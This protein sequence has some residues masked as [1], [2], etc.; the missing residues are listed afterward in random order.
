MGR[1][2][3]QLCGLSVL[4]YTDPQSYYVLAGRAAPRTRWHCTGVNGGHLNLIKEVPATLE[5]GH[6]YT[7][8]VDARGG[9]FIAYLD[10]KQMFAVD[11]G[12]LAKGP[13]GF[14]RRT[15][16]GSASTISS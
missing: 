6:W 14:G 12:S 13:S 8:K 7:F 4:R 3:G 5:R 15:I 16:R 2:L 11:D 9:H 1:R 10:G